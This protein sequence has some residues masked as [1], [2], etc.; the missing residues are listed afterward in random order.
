MQTTKLSSKG[1]IVLPSAM[2]HARQWK[3]GMTL[4]LEETSEGILLKA[5]KPFPVTKIE[6]VFA[7][8]KYKGPPI[9]IDAMNVAIEEEMQKRWLKKS[10]K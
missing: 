1:Q 2:R 4:T 10:R 7:C 3:P 8:L 6:D 9:T 5:A